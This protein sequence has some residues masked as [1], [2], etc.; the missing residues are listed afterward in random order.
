MF[1]YRCKFQIIDRW[2]GLFVYWLSLFIDWSCQKFEKHH[3]NPAMCFLLK[4]ERERIYTLAYTPIRIYTCVL[5]M[6]GNDI[7]FRYRKTRKFIGISNPQVSILILFYTVLL[8]AWQF[9]YLFILTDWLRKSV[10]MLWYELK[11]FKT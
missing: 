4:I 6:S 2:N 5:L 9:I 10:H 3:A 1:F 8:A 11:V 7:L